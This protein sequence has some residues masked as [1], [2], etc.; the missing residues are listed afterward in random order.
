MS[1]PDS[2]CV[3]SRFVEVAL[4]SETLATDI[5]FLPFLA[6][7]TI[8][9]GVYFPTAFCIGLIAPWIFPTLFS[10]FPSTAR[11]RFLVA[12]PT[13][14][15]RAPSTSRSLSCALFHV[16]VFIGF[17]FSVPSR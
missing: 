17:T 7:Q 11:L 14:S 4:T 15:R 1:G 5:S 3:A 2:P 12:A 6:C 8:G 10:N 16:L 13:A 9:G